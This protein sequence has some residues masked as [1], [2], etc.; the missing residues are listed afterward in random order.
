MLQRLW[1]GMRQDVVY[2][3][4]VMVSL[5]RKLSSKTSFSYVLDERGEMTKQ[6][7]M[8]KGMDKPVISVKQSGPFVLNFPTHPIINKA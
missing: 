4:A 8:M 1:F 7:P 6:M 2:I 5:Y 3:H